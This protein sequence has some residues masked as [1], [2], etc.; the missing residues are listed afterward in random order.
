MQAGSGP[1]AGAPERHARFLA[2]LEESDPRNIDVSKLRRLAAEDTESVVASRTQLR[3]LGVGLAAA[4][5]PLPAYRPARQGK[6]AQPLT[7][8]PPRRERP[9]ADQGQQQV[10]AADANDTETP[11]LTPPPRHNCAVTDDGHGGENDTEDSEDDDESETGETVAGETAT[12]ESTGETESGSA[13][14]PASSASASVT[15][16]EDEERSA[17]ISKSPAGS[18]AAARPPFPN[19]ARAKKAAASPPARRLRAA[20]VV[21]GA[22][23][24]LANGTYEETEASRNGACI[25]RDT[26]TRCELSYELINGRTG[27]IIGRTPDAFYG[28]ASDGVVPPKGGWLMF[29]GVPPPPSCAAKPLEPAESPSTDE[30]GVDTFEAAYAPSGEV[31]PPPVPPREER[32][33]AQALTSGGGAAA[34][35]DT[36]DTEDESDIDFSGDDL[37]DALPQS[38]TPSPRAA[39]TATPNVRP[40]EFRT[41]GG[42]PPKAPRPTS[43]TPW[44]YGGGSS[45]DNQFS[46]R[47]SAATLATM[48]SDDK[49]AATL[50]PARTT[51]SPK[52]TDS[53]AAA[54]PRPQRTTVPAATKAPAEDDDLGSSINLSDS[55]LSYNLSDSLGSLGTGEEE[56]DLSDV[57]GASDLSEV[58]EGDDEEAAAAGAPAQ[59]VET[60]DSA[61]KTV[62]YN[63]T[64]GERRGVAMKK[65]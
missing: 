52:K 39:D 27:W 35:L 63:T 42:M 20:F 5:P 12:T 49:A 26:R 25:Y 19:E 33:A 15:H 2:L 6:A 58:V 1:Y 54:P 40:A 44:G 36:L 47:T 59:W 11:L 16:D 7:L 51:L 29:A 28:V 17:S 34:D 65:Y 43:S 62:M 53:T 4:L 21:T 45:E 60:L 22:G 14:T 41:P 37:D 64:T 23:T 24:A 8:T 55:G 46:G 31:L 56:L 13:S 48:L 10:D 32:L 30:G 3:D 50:P 57:S 61:K 38:R 9:P 18:S